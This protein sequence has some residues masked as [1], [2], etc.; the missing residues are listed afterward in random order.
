MAPDSRSGPTRLPPRIRGHAFATIGRAGLVG[1]GTR[2]YI[3]VHT[4]LNPRFVLSKPPDRVKYTNFA[5]LRKDL[6][7]IEELGVRRAFSRE[8]LALTTTPIRRLCATSCSFV[9][10]TGTGHSE[11]HIGGRGTEPK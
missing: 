1:C 3:I 5:L 2:P 6:E 10:M 11:S 8:P 9:P 7:E 4:L